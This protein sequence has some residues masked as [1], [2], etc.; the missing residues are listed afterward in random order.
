MTAIEI[1]S[2][3]ELGEIITIGT[4]LF[5]HLYSRALAQGELQIGGASVEAIRVTGGK[6]EEHANDSDVQELKITFKRGV[7]DTSLFTIRKYPPDRTATW[8]I[9][10]LSTEPSSPVIIRYD[11]DQMK[12]ESLL[13]G[14]AGR[15]RLHFTEGFRRPDRPGYQKDEQTLKSLHTA[16]VG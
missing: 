13:E 5:G 8:S 16:V 2:Q 4:E 14:K 6:T 7:N 12:E 3:E 10:V 15:N 1:V 11:I 9:D